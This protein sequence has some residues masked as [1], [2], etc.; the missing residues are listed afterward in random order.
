MEPRFNWLRFIADRSDILIAVLVVGIVMMMIIP[1]P[2]WLLDILLTF[3]ISFALVILMVSMFNAEPLDFSVFPSL[4]LIMTMFRLALNVS[5]TRLI[6]L[7]AY[8]GEVISTFGSFVIGGNTVVGFIIFLILVV[9]QFIV[10]TRGAE[11]VSEVAARFTLDAMPGKQMAI[12][13]DLNAGLI[14]EDEARTRRKNIQ[15]E[16]DFYGAMDGASKFVRGDAIAG[17]IIVIINIIG[18]LII[19]MVQRGMTASEAV[20]IYT[21]LTVGDGLVT[22][23]PALLISTATGIVVTRSASQSNLGKELSLQVLNYPRA[24][25]LAALILFALG[26][27]GLPRIPMYALGAFF[28]VL[29]LLSRNAAQPAEKTEIAEDVA[30]AEQIKRPENVLELLQVEKM[31]ME[32]GYGLIPLVDTDQGGDLL[33]RIVMIRRQCAVE[34]GFIVPPIRIRDNMQLKP[35]SYLIKIK[36]AEIASGELLLDNY[37]AIGPD[38]ENDIDLPGVDT[39]EPAFNLPA[40]WINTTQKD[41]AEMKGYTVVDPPSVL[42]T[43]LTAVIK[44]HAYELLGRQDVQNMVDYIKEQNP[45]VVTDLIPDIISLSELQ[46]VL[47]NLLRE[48]VS[49]RDLTTILETLADYGR[50]TKD[51]DVLTEY[52]R[53][54]LRRQI[55]RQYAGDNK[56][57]Q[58]LTLD[59]AVEDILRESIQQS[60][61]G[62][63][64][65]VDPEVAQSLI[66]KVARYHEEL[67]RKGTTPI[68]LCAPILRI[69]FKRLLDRF[70]ND[71]VVL[72]YNEIDSNVQVEVVGMVTA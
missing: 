3:N 53:Q 44:S 24:L 19:G 20:E 49:I 50:L 45:A 14:N 9:I 58:V 57:L 30:E 13:A 11:R 36:G 39:V 63:Y 1:M 41:Q 42:A 40:R 33:D 29:Y 23:I 18:G 8:A 26:S 2:T 62:S 51:T 55:T 28:A 10:I 70:M 22:Q 31:E 7:N 6:L 66:N 12:D 56:K 17:I 71:L 59:P 5:S 72:S 35:N 15:R 32:L 60:E 67:I 37:L 69:Y 52:V 64:L 4:L 16:A 34:L 21:I 68:I 48:Q 43:H 47:S 27:I 38:I 54:A 46:K 25:G 61:F 65:A